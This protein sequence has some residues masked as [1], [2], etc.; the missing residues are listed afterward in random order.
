MARELAPARLRSS[1]LHCLTRGSAK[2][3]RGKAKGPT[4]SS[5]S[6]V[7]WLGNGAAYSP[8]SPK[9]AT[10]VW[11]PDYRECESYQ[12][13]AGTDAPA[14]PLYST[15]AVRGRSSDLPVFLC[16]RFANLRT[17]TTQSFGDD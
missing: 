17:A 9:K 8:S 6:D 13:I 15:A 11:R 12:L 10:R 5:E 4:Q 3:D 14:K 1:R 16:N 2:A 7:L